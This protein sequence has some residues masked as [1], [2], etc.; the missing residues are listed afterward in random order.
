MSD[1]TDDIKAN[2][3]KL[4]PKG[5]QPPS[6]LSEMEQKVLAFDLESRYRLAKLQDECSRAEE[7]SADAVDSPTKVE[8]SLTPKQKEL[9]AKAKQHNQRKG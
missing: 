4:V 7:L 5:R 1:D 6:P 9:A 3:A 2:F 8:Q